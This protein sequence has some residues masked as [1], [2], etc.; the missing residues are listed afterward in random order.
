M[1]AFAFS[2][3]DDDADETSPEAPSYA[4]EGFKLEFSE[5]VA[6]TTVEAAP[7]PKPN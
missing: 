4:L 6:L 5:K 1:K 3:D 7:P 2:D